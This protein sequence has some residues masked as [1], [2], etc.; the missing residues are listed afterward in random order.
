MSVTVGTL[1]KSKREK[2][3]EDEFEKEIEEETVKVHNEAS[4]IYV[5]MMESLKEVLYC[6]LELCLLH[7]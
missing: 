5:E 7:Q 3:L 1:K 2:Q 4:Q 6:L